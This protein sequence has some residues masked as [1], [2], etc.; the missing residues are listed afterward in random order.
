M[1]IYEYPDK[2]VWANIIER[3]HLDMSQLN[4]IVKDV[5]DDIRKNG[6]SA[7]KNYEEK[8]DKVSL[9]YLAVSEEEFSEAENLVSTD[10]KVALEQAHG[11]IARFHE[12]QKLDFN[13]VETC[14]GVT[15]WQI[16]R[17]HV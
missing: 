5:L 3:P 15:C 8:F 6:D 1:K 7:V 16:G 11:N 10:L 9:N 2:K 14:K 17:A 12:S 13:K 4:N